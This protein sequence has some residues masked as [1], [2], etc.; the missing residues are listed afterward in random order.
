MKSV[1]VARVFCLLGLLFFIRTVSAASYHVLRV[2]DGDTLVASDGVIEFKVRI[3]GLDAPEMAQD[4]G[5]LA[6]TF[7]SHLID[8]KKITV[9]PLSSG[10]DRYN[11]VLAHVF[12]KKDDVALLLI[13]EGLAYY[14][15]PACT[16]Y[17]DNNSGYDFDPKPYVAAE[18][19]AQKQKLGVWSGPKQQ[20]PCDYRKLHPI[21]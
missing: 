17:A 6:K 14:Y 4:Y 2:I 11:R 7:L 20:L 21:E 5:P 3:A 8:D 12:L 18:Q 1:R 16:D 19:T 15:R 13:K 10:L 9:Q